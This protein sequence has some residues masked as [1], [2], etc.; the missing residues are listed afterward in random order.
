MVPI[1]L[2]TLVDV[3]RGK[4]VLVVDFV[5]DDVEVLD[6]VIAKHGRGPHRHIKGNPVPCTDKCGGP[7]LPSD[8]PESGDEGSDRPLSHL[9]K[10][11]WG[12]MDRPPDLPQLS[13]GEYIRGPFNEV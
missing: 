11:L 8:F 10:V 12:F 4:Q 5:H 9:G 7:K 3:A 13:W 1:K 2:E 6:Y